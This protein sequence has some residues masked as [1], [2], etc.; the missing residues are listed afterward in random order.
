[1]TAAEMTERNR[2]NAQH[3]TGPRTE[4]GKAASSQN[5]RKHGLSG[6]LI[7]KTKAESDRYQKRIAKVARYYKLNNPLASATIE[8]LV[9][10]ARKPSPPSRMSSSNSNS[11]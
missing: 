9:T 1:M 11:R 6:K 3:S 5:A 10:A 7:L 2:A 4:D 8:G